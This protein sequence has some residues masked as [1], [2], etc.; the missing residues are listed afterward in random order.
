VKA[1]AVLRWGQGAHTPYILPRP[2][3]FC[4]GNLGLT[5]PHVNHLRWK[6]L[7]KLLEMQTAF[8]DVIACFA[9]V[10]TLPVASATTELSFSVMRHVK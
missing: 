9:L 6:L 7:Q 1:V 5:L 8:P 4:Q 2:Q 10:L 3:K